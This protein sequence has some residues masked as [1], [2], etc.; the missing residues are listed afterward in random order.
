[1]LLVDGSYHSR[2]WW[3]CVKFMSV[4]WKI[5]AHWKGAAVLS[6]MVSSSPSEDRRE[7]RL[8]RD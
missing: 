4:L 5:A 8:E 7:G 6:Q 3:P 1:M 2:L